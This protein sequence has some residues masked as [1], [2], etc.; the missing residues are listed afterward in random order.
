MHFD[1]QTVGTSRG[2]SEC[3]AG[4]ESRNAGSMRR[5]RE[6]REGTLF[7]GENN[8]VDIERIAGGRFKCTDSAFAQNDIFISAL[9]K[10]VSGEQPFFEQSR[11]SALEEHGFAQVTEFFQE[12]III[13]VA[14]TDL[15]GVDH[16]VEIGD[17][18]RVRDF[19][20]KGHPRFGFDL[21]DDIVSLTAEALKGFRVRAQF[22]NATA[23][24]YGALLF[25]FLGNC[26]KL[27]LGFYGTG[28]SPDAEISSP[29]AIRTD[30]DDLSFHCAYVSNRSQPPC[31]LFTARG[32]GKPV[33]TAVSGCQTSAKGV[34]SPSMSATSMAWLNTSGGRL[35][36]RP[37]EWSPAP[38]GDGSPSFFAPDFALNSAQPWLIGVRA[39]LALEPQVLPPLRH[40]A[41]PSS[42][43][44]S[45]LFE[46]IQT[47]ISRNDFAKVVPI[48]CEELEFAEPLHAAMF[49]HAIL[50]TRVHQFHYGFE[51][52][53]EGLVGVTP[54]LLFSVEDG[55]LRT[56]A[57][58]GTAKADG[59][60]LLD[61]P[62]EMYEHRLVVDHIAGVLRT[63]GKPVVGQ[64]IE[65]TF[66]VLKHLYTPLQVNLNTVP[67]FLDLVVKLH[68]T[69]AL[70][71]W[72]RQPAVE[73]LEAQDFHVGRRRFGAPFGY[74][75]GERMMCVVAIRALQWQG[76]CA[77]VAAGCGIVAQSEALREWNELRLKREAIA[78]N[79]GLPL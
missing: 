42:A 41:E 62:K 33:L 9:H 59:A 79:L 11:K 46:D 16:V 18:A 55:V 77:Q 36:I 17:L 64:T 75:D 74:V 40:R 51:F 30:C 71:G 63:W 78:R 21:L 12:R 29:Y 52:G 5:I 32:R 13:H 39:D 54:E 7:F 27:L 14:R 69:A 2:C 65:R 68:P 34:N 43:D 73:W 31:H 28:A 8:G 22:K 37:Q 67:Q 20:N 50:E 4:N 60:C 24:A 15:K 70:G 76:P 35:S 44:F 45:N 61:D 19:G 26:L 25:D 72:P 49:A 58:A 56:M 3:D 53:G 48:V 23:Q 6:N 38:A 47:R 10:V 66:G 57:L 1:Q